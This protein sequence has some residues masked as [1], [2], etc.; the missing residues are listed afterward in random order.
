[1]SL[2]AIADLHLSTE[3]ST[4]KSM[5]IFGDRWKNYTEKIKKNWNLV[6]GKN[7]TV[8]IPGDISWA[9]SISQ[10]ESDLRFID[11]LNG[12]KLLG[13][14]NHDFWWSTE[15]KIKEFF[16]EKGLSTLSLLHNNAY[17]IGN[18]IVCGSRGWFSDESQQN[19]VYNADY[20]KI[21][22]REVIRLSLSLDQAI[23]LQNE[24]FKNNGVKL[25]IL[26]FLHFPPVKSNDV[27]H[28]ITNLLK[29][30]K[31]TDCFYGHIHNSYDIPRSFF[32]ENIRYTIISSDFLNF[33]PLKI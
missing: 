7:D 26:V 4:Q 2:F 17:L 30:Y 19:A 25:P 8:I 32:Y 21:I 16:I 33:C 14:G 18:Y 9:M 20:K 28:E 31:I 24:N 22:N 3:K 27:I 15:K 11:S 6:V 10:A 5:E 12:R 13:K 29:K 1:M 23:H